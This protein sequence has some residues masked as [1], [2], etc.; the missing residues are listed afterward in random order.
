MD[1]NRIVRV[2]VERLPKPE[3]GGLENGEDAPAG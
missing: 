3:A 2:R 1:F